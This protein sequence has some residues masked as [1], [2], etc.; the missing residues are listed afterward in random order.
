MMIATHN[1]L[2]WQKMRP[3]LRLVLILIVCII[4]MFF[5]GLPVA[6]AAGDAVATGTR[7]GGNETRTRFVAD[8]SKT[9]NYSVYIL[10]DPYRVVIDL[11]DVRFDL[12]P[13]IGHK[14]RGLVSQYRYGL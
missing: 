1:V 9:V 3:R 13:G 11:P 2:E 12:P 7:V 4:S 10:P 14:V 8:I 6:L 5:S